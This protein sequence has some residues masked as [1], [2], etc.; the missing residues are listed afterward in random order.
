MCV[1][2]GLVVNTTMIAV[3]AYQRLKQK[4]NEEAIPTARDHGRR[5]L[6][7]L[8]TVGSGTICWIFHT[9]AY[10]NLVRFSHQSDLQ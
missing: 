8:T 10:R 4:G 6:L 5:D 2:T 1:Y 3:F 7:S 9:S